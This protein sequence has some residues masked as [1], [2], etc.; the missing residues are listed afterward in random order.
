MARDCNSVNAGS[1]P[2]RASILPIK[3]NILRL[4]VLVAFLTQIKPEVLSALSRRL[5]GVIEQL[6]IIWLPLYTIV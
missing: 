2:T 1:I 4:P 6:S 5:W 3:I